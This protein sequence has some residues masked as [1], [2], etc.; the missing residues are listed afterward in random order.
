MT[1]SVSP[2]WGDLAVRTGS[3]AI[4]IPVVL[5]CVWFGGL[6]FQ[7]FVFLF[8]CLIAGEWSR[9]V[10]SGNQGQYLLHLGAAL[11]GVL[12]PGMLA[13]WVVAL[14]VAALAAVSSFLVYSQ[15][16]AASH[17]SYLGIWYV[18]LPAIALSVLRS[19]VEFGALAIVWICV[20]VWSADIF[21]YFAG[22]IIGGPK[23]APAISPK[24]TWAGLAGAVFGSAIASLIF[25]NFA[26][27]E[28]IGILTALA[29]VLAIVEQGGDLFES[30]LKRFH[31][32][33]DAGSLIPGHGGVIDRVDGLI[34][35]SVA[36]VLIGFFR[37]NGEFAAQGLLIW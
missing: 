14:L 13:L 10:H 16:A 8:G 21:A 29:G 1:D 28:S 5:L 37:M 32:V 6:W 26:Q 18:G 15:N 7:I 12:A 35:V 22:R 9:I 11:L 27:L 3:A 2:K 30:A 31:N 4:L 33:K 25:A 19:D 17:W 36:A 20:I 34:A 23:L 24:K